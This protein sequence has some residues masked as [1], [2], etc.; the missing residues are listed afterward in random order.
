[1][2]NLVGVESCRA[3]FFITGNGYT[4]DSLDLKFIPGAGLCESGNGGRVILS[5]DAQN[6][7][8][9]FQVAGDLFAN[10][11]PGTIRFV[12]IS[13]SPYDFSMSDKGV[14]EVCLLEEKVLDDYFKLC[15]DNGAKPVVSFCLSMRQLKKPT[16]PVS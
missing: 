2:S 9:S 11:E 7:Q 5:S 8:Q 3:D 10:T 14:S 16:M 4:R 15:V 12:L 6:L 13:L 1:M